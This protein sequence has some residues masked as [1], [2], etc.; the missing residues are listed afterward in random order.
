MIKK[1][2]PDKLSTQLE[3]I[4]TLSIFFASI[5]SSIPGYI[6]FQHEL[7]QQTWTRIDDG[8]LATLALL[9]TER[10]RLENVAH[11]LSTRPTFIS[12]IQNSEF[13]K[14]EEYL[15]TYQ[16]SSKVDFLV[17]QLH[18]GQTLLCAPP[19]CPNLVIPSQDTSFYTINQSQQK[20]A[21]IVNRRVVIDEGTPLT[22][23]VGSLLDTNYVHHLKDKTGKDY[24][25]LAQKQILV[26]TVEHLNEVELIG[27][28]ESNNNFVFHANEEIYYA[29]PISLADERGSVIAQLL[30]SNSIRTLQIANL[31]AR[32]ALITLTIVVSLC[33]VGLAYLFSK[34]VTASLSELTRA[35]L[36]I[37]QGDLNTPAPVIK[38]PSEIRDLGKAFELGRINTLHALEI[39]AQEKKWSEMLIQ[40]I[41][42]GIIT[43]D[44]RGTITSFSQGA[45]KILGYDKKDVLGLNIDQFIIPTDY[46]EK[47][48]NLLRTHGTLN[49][50]SIRHQDGSELIVS[51]SA[52]QFQLQPENINETILVL[53]DVTEEEHVRR[54]RSYFLANISHEFRT[55]LSSLNASVELLLEQIEKLSHEEMIQ[56]L[57]SIHLSVTNLQTLIDNLL[58]SASIEAGRLQIRRGNFRLE[59]IIEQAIQ[60]MRPLLE[61]RNQNI[62]CSFSQELPEAQVDATR[63]IQ[64]IVNLLSNASKYSPMH[65]EINITL[66]KQ[67]N[68]FLVEVWDQGPGIPEHELPKLFTRFV[69]LKNTPHT[70]Y[71]VG[72]GLS[73]VKAIVEQHGGKVGARNH[74]VKGSIFWFTIPMDQS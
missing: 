9:D 59:S 50:L 15:S 38:H 22:I 45:E 24:I 61:R 70:L 21:L 6:I 12:L 23:V 33:G 64:V 37:S 48:T 44:E 67:A 17:V 11:N 10:A 35:A 66:R 26:S 62:R 32:I 29:K 42:E 40:S 13:T 49:Q 54:L 41:S 19:L 58:E 27:Y 56:L 65:S 69:R 20:L 16:E 36:K 53:R 7:E 47:F 51:V 1:L 52:A 18:E 71:G 25:L 73:V 34:K 43:F 68:D 28:P 63:M 55:P 5:A 72:L 46:E 2:F 60:V 74:P 14:S 39:L 3:W 30:V 31:S 4:I 8:V 57:K